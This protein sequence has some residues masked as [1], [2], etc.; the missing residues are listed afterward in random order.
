MIASW[1]ESCDKPR[2]C[3]KKQRHHFVNK[4]LCS[5]GYGLSSSHVWMWEL[6]NKESRVL[7]NWCFPAVALEKTLESPLESKEIKPVNFKGNQPW[8]L[9]E[10]TDAEAEASIFDHLRRTADSL[11]KTLML[12][13]IEGRKRRGWQRVRRLDSITNSMDL[14]L[15]KLQE[16]VKDREAWHATVHGIAKS[17][18]RLGDWTTIL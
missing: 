12:W 18:T 7:K 8:I 3:V 15:D 17:Q 11:E 13:K 14:N 2:H 4:G 1:K 6:Y 9:F 10:R 16:I 5:Q